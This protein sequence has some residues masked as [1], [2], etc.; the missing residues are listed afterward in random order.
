MIR[1][2]DMAADPLKI[3]GGVAGFLGLDPPRERLQRAIAHSSFKALKA[4]EDERGFVE[5]SQYSRFFRTGQVGRWKEV[6]SAE[7]VDRIV[8]DHREQMERFGY[9]PDSR[10]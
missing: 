2:E 7:Q 1:Y 5:R 8:S 3:F 10:R 4:Q 9:V 6:L